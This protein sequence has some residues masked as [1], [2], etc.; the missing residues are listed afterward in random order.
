MCPKKIGFKEK[1]VLVFSITF[2]WKD[3]LKIHL[4]L[5]T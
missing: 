5:L 1:L 2:I 3:L 4:K